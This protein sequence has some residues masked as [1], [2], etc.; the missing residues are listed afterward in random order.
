MNG[1]VNIEIVKKVARG[2]E[3]LLD[4][5]V[6]VGGAIMELYADTPASTPL[7]PTTDVDIVV[8]LVGYG[9]YARL[10][11]ELSKLGFHHDSE[12]TLVCRYKFEGITVDIMPTDEDILGF[13]NQWYK[14][15][16]DFVYDHQLDEGV[17]IKLFQPSYFLASKFE[18]FKGRGDDH[19]TSHDFE[20]IIY[21]LDNRK[22]WKEEILV[23]DIEVREYLKAEFKRLLENKFHKEY[24]STHL[25]V[26]NKKER[27]DRIIDGLEKVVQT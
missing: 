26:P 8:E 17:Q 13:S 19:R 16:M 24:I 20:D 27:V 22:N 11:E 2:L 23:A 18:A 25:P 14:P 1:P 21:F 12:S 6:F 9:N 5:L 7:R 15:G 3:P 4:K 10:E